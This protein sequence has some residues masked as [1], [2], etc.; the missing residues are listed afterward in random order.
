MDVRVGTWS[1][2]PARATIEYD[3]A[4][5]YLLAFVACGS[6]GYSAQRFRWMLRG[7]AAA[8]LV[9]CLCGLTTRLA[10]DPSD[11]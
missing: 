1:A 8:A 4:L 10:P 3:R 5:L 2:A 7:L 6:F 9:V 11:S